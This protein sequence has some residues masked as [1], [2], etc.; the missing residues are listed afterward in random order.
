MKSRSNQYTIYLFLLLIIIA[1]SKEEEINTKVKE[2]VV[3]TGKIEKISYQPVIITSG[4]IHSQN[5][6]KLS[7]K[8]GGIIKQIFVSEGETVK[9]GQ[10]LASLNLSEIEARVEQ[11]KKAYEKAVR[12]HDRVENLY[13]DSVATLEQ[14]QDAGTG[15][16]VAGSNLEIAEFNLKYSNITAPADGRILMKLSEE[17]ELAGPGQPL[18]VFGAT[19]TDFVIRVGVTDKDL[20]K[21]AMRDKAKIKV[22]AYPDFEFSGIVSEIGQAADSY[23]GTYEVE[24]KINP[25]SKKLAS[26]FVGKV[27]IYP[28]QLV[29]VNRIPVE[30]LVEANKSEGFVFIPKG[31]DGSVEKVKIRIE[32]IAGE[33]ILV[34]EGLENINEIVTEGSAYLTNTS[35]IKIYN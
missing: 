28:S 2:I 29:N 7:F 1:C 5:E 25:E 8:T 14:F 4:K 23:N 15:L 9:K 24:V 11:A 34:S 26:G 21:L 27:E 22:D 32:A 30:S 10:L 16:S 17:N 33:S 20:V 12:D 3:K 35:K 13:N 19:D 18:F 6:V 31:N